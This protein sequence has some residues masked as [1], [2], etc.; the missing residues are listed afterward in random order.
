MKRLEEFYDKTGIVDVVN[1]IN[2]VSVP[3][4]K[5]LLERVDFDYICQGT[6]V[7]FH[8]DFTV[9]NILVTRDVQTNL[10][11]FTLLDWR[12]DFG[13]LTEMGDIYYDLA[14]L[15][16]GI[17]LSDEL[18]TEGMFSFD[19]SG[20]SVYYDY[21]SKNQLVEAKEEYESFL[22]QNGFD[23]HKVKILTAIALLNMSPL[24]KEPFN[25]LVYFLGKSLLYKTLNEMDSSSELKNKKVT[26]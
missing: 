1:N 17:I 5:N 2:G 12:Q 20:T 23:L 4:L 9:G 10:N 18:I 14:K 8:G 13:G 26:L 25:F 24:H 6:P 7:R 15:Y 16:K 22:V 3:S 19:M 11:K 21:F